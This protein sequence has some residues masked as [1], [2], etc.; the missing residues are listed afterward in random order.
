MASLLLPSQLDNVFRGRKA[1][2][3][4]LVLVLLSKL[5]MGTNI[6]LNARSVAAGAD[7]IPLDRFGNGG[8]EAVIAFFA[9]WGMG[10]ILLAAL[11]TLALIR[12]RAMVP[13]IW[14][15]FLVEH[16]ARKAVFAAYPVARAGTAMVA[17]GWSAATLIN[18]ILLLVL[19]VGLALSLWPRRES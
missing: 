3:G 6:L 1:S 2:L 18:L 11:G 5:A 15:L 12:Y 4:L 14:L 13:L 10:Q 17:P 9:L 16:L 19:A 7:G 8:A